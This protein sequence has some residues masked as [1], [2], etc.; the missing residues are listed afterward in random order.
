MEKLFVVRTQTRTCGDC[1]VYAEKLRVAG[2]T[3]INLKS[4]LSKFKSTRGF[5]FG[6]LI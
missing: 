3:V 6:A 1:V 4:K 5:V 2:N